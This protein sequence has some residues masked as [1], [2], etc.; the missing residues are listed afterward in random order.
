MKPKRKA[1]YDLPK[2]DYVVCK[3]SWFVHAGMAYPVISA[4][5]EVFRSALL[6]R[7]PNLKMCA[8]YEYVVNDELDYATRW[9][10]K[11]EIVL[12]ESREA[13]QQAC[14]EQMVAG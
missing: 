6:E 11:R 10:H 2:V 9:W 12:Y 3:R 8:E 7:Y 13:A 5:V 4:P 1:S 14:V